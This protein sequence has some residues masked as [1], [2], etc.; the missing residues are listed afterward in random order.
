MGGF[1]ELFVFKLFPSLMNALTY[2]ASEGP[3]NEA[4][5]HRGRRVHVPVDGADD[6]RARGAHDVAA[7]VA[8]HTQRA[9]GLEAAPAGDLEGHLHAE[10]VLDQHD[11]LPLQVLLPPPQSPDLPARDAVQYVPRPLKQRQV[12]AVPPRDLW[13]IDSSSSSSSEGV[14][15]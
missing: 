6:G 4:R 10:H 9:H 15:G 3:A 2:L 5:A 7:P 13:P 1:D 11:A 14:R 12:L 8:L